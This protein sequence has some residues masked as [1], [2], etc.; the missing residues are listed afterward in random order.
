MT[1]AAQPVEVA[2]YDPVWPRK[3]LEERARIAAALGDTDAVIEHIGSTAV[4]GLPAKPVIDILIGVDDIERSGQAVAALI[5]LGYN[6]APE[7]ES[8]V[9]DQRYFYKGSPHT[10]HVHM[11]ERS[12]RMFADHLLFRDYLRAHPEAAD[13]YARLKRGL[14]ARFRDDRASYTRGKQTFF[15]T[16]VAAA[17]RARAAQS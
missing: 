8:E 17:R 14:A 5:G 7:V 6:Y 9:P 15:D 1:Q 3:F 4:P 11:V 12:S 13:E 16:V 2:E 10:H